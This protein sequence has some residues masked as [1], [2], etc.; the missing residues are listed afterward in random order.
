MKT[1]VTLQI[2]KT[3]GGN[4]LKCPRL[5]PLLVGSHPG[6]CCV[7]T[8]SVFKVYSVKS[9]AAMPKYQCKLTSLIIFTA[10]LV[11]PSLRAHIASLLLIQTK[12]LVSR[13]E[14]G[15][16]KHQHFKQISKNQSFKLT[17][18]KNAE[19]HLLT[20][21]QIPQG[22]QFALLAFPTAKSTEN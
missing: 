5:F 12:T 21:K 7:I 20:L 1:T 4:E 17:S 18:K 11:R 10:S 22:G 14:K 9:I 8:G 3:E 19:A 2:R 13:P 6:D 15:E 16:I